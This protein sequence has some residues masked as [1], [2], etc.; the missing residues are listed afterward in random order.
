M[1]APSRIFEGDYSAPMWAA[2]NSAETVEDLRSALYLVCCRLQELESQLRGDRAALQA[3]LN[4]AL[5]LVLR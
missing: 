1:T 2:I 3:T 5:P 4:R